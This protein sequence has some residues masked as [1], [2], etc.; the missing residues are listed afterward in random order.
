MSSP[1]DV[2]RRIHQAR[3]FTG[4]TLVDGVQVP[5][6]AIAT[7]VLCSVQRIGRTQAEELTKQGKRISDFRRIYCEQKIPLSDEVVTGTSARIPLG[8]DMFETGTDLVIDTARGRAQAGQVF[9]DHDWYE[10][11]ERHP[12]QNGVINHYQYLLFR[13]NHNDQTV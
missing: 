11:A 7:T 3:V 12:M 10:V 9:I 13:V 2:F 1:L 8:D 4:A 5:G 6:T